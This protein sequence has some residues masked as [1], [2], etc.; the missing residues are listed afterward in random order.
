MD[1]AKLYK[2]KKM[3]YFL[4]IDQG[5]SSTRAI[6]FDEKFAVVNVSQTEFKQFFPKDG[7]V[8]HDANEIFDTVIGCI[9]DVM[10]KSKTTYKEIIAIGITNQRE[11]CLL[12]DKEG[13]PLGKA[14]VW[15]DRR[16]VELCNNFKK[17]G[18][19]KTINQ[20]TG[21]L[22]DPYFSGTKLS[23]LLD[24]TATPKD[25]YMGT[26]DTFLVWKLTDGRSYFI[27][28]TNASRTLLMDINNVSWSEE[29]CNLLNIPIDKLPEIKNSA[30]EYGETSLFGGEIKI[31]GIAG[32][33]QAALF[34]Q[35]CFKEGEAKSTYGT[36]C[37]MMLNTGSEIKLSKSKLLSTIG[38]QI[39]GKV[40]Y[41]LEGSIFMAGAS[42]QWLRDNLEFFSLAQEI[43]NLAKN[44]NVNS[45]VSF[46]PAFTG[47][48][49]PYWDPEARGAIFGLSRETTKNDISQ[50]L[51]EAIA[52]Q[53]KDVFECMSS[54]GVDLK[55]LKIDGGMVENKYFNQILADVLNLKILLPDNKEATAKGAAFL[56]SL[57]SN[58]TNSLSDL[59][60]FVGSY[61]EFTPLESRDSKYQS[62]KNLVTKIL[63]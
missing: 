45:N 63:A 42:V 9:K 47:L 57:G 5:T 14:I 60:E 54:D 26:I 41:A 4:V 43:E 28:A 62:W 46:I 32:D 6:L 58:H 59:D 36:G 19:D 2:P 7:W 27:D 49:A 40:N 20:I 15:Q 13:N 53:T 29:M 1:N 56:A 37:F 21:L 17:E 23:W 3:K 44:S 30:D 12:W 48:G 22:A 35:G 51:L 8:E 61:E 33:Q 39:D 16:T 31:C 55:S 52:F 50:A 10:T 11:T 38:Y 24:N 25:F 34:G 18:L